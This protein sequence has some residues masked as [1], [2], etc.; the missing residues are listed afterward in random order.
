MLD[1]QHILLDKNAIEHIAKLTLNRPERLNTLNVLTMDELGA[2]LED[3]MGDDSVR[4]LVV[5]GAG[6]GVCAGGDSST[7]WCPKRS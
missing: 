6:R 7:S 2:A 3:V 1:Y 4:V 5:T